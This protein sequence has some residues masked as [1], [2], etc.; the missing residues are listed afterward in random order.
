MNFFNRI[1]KQGAQHRHFIRMLRNQEKTSDNKKESNKKESNKKESDEAIE[2]NSEEPNSEND[3]KDNGHEMEFDDSSE[4]QEVLNN[5]EVNDL[6][7]K[8]ISEAIEVLKIERNIAEVLLTKY[9]WD[10]EKLILDF[11]ENSDKIYDLVDIKKKKKKK[12]ENKSMECSVCLDVINEGDFASL[13]CQHNFC[14][15]CWSDYLK[16]NINEGQTIGIMCMQKDC[17]QTVP[18]QIIR[19]LVEPDVYKKYERFISKSYVETNSELRWCSTPGCE[20]VIFNPVKLGC[21]L[22]AE[23]LCGN[24]FCYNCKKEAH[25]PVTCEMIKEWDEYISTLDK[26]SL[27]WLVDHEVDITTLKWMRDFTK[28]CPKCKALVQKNGGCFYMGCQK[29]GEGWCWGCGQSWAPSHSSHFKC[30]VAN[31][32]TLGF[33]SKPILRDNKGYNSKAKLLEFSKIY[34]VFVEYNKP[35]EWNEIKVQDNNKLQQLQEHIPNLDSKF[36]H[37][38]RIT[39]KKAQLTLKYSAV[40]LF[41]LKRRKEKIETDVYKLRIKILANSL[42]SLKDCF[43]KQVIVPAEIR[44]QTKV[45]SNSMQNLLEEIPLSEMKS[46]YYKIH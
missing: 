41:L 35:I 25:P 17:N 21:I 37:K 29:C 42:K 27:S 28:P 6:R 33:D 10:L 15:N 19:Q 38:G 46:K 9:S 45:L 1:S 31:V 39:M 23:C 22:V 34:A 11:F 40:R 18:S 30:P 14:T 44:K 20:Y 32:Q 24:I 3:E 36:I 13:E 12:K 5:G 16:L 2:E 4:N 26:D 7:E 43:D 8:Q